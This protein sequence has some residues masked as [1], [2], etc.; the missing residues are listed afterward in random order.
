VARLADEYCDVG[1][2]KLHVVRAGHGGT[3]VVLEAGSGCGADLWRAVQEQAGEFTATYSYDRAGQGSSDPAGPWSLMGWVDDLESWLSAVQVQPPY[4]LVGHS[5]G[6]HI[7]RALAARRP[8]DVMGMVLVDARSESLFPEL[9][10][11]FRARLAELVPYDAEQGFRADAIVR[12][13]PGLK[14][15][16]LSVLTHGRFDWIPDA[17]GLD[18]AD[19]DHAELAWQRHQRALAA[20][21]SR[22]RFV[23]ASRS[24]HLI[25]IDQPDLIA[26]EIRAAIS[27]REES[28]R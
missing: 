9:P 12:E 18:Q 17:F 21:S 27:E 13:L 10:A 8:E 15:L 25:P 22:S 6:G 4:L 14:D 16:P 26:G 1:G 11:A 7:V 23:V 5:L 19:L 24:G 28:E 3:P 20:L 2:R